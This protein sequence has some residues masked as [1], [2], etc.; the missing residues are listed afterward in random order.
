MKNRVY[1]IN[2]FL[3]FIFCSCGTA[4]DSKHRN[5]DIINN[6]NAYLVIKIKEYTAGYVI[7][8]QR[9]DSVFKVLSFKGEEKKLACSK[10]IENKKYDL[11][12]KSCFEDSIV[13]LNHLGGKHLGKDIIHIE[14]VG[15]VRDL[16]YDSRLYGLCLINGQ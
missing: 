7:Y 4:K 6:K 2:Y 12:L 15:T 13:P 3:L 11:I 5:A 10:L 14:E 9:N 8:A 16:F 1:Y